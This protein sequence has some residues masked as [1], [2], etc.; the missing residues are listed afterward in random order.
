MMLLFGL[1][2]LAADVERCGVDHDECCVDVD[3]LG[4]CVFVNVL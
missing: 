1:A 4:E 2:D 3:V